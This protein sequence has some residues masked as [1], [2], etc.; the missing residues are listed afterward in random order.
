[1]LVSIAL[2]IALV[3]DATPGPT[4]QPAQ[5]SLLLAP[6]ISIAR[7]AQSPGMMTALWTKQ[8]SW[9]SNDKLTD[10][11]L[12]QG[13]RGNLYIRQKD[14][15]AAVDVRT[16][17]ERWSKTL[18]D[19]Y[20][21][22]AND[23]FLVASLEDG[24]LISLRPASGAVVWNLKLAERPLLAFVRG[25]LLVNLDGIDPK[26]GTAIWS[27]RTLEKYGEPVWLARPPHDAGAS[28]LIGG[29]A[30]GTIGHNI[31]IALD[32]TS[33]KTLWTADTDAF[34]GIAAGLVYMQDTW[35]RDGSAVYLDVNGQKN[36]ETRKEYVL[37]PDPAMNGDGDR[38]TDTVPIRVTTDSILIALN[39]WFYRYPRVNPMAARPLRVASDGTFLGGPID[40]WYYFGGPAGLT[41]VNF[42]GTTASKRRIPLPGGQSGPMLVDDSRVYVG[43]GSGRLIEIDTKARTVTRMTPAQCKLPHELAMLDGVLLAAC[44]DERKPPTPAP[45]FDQPSGERYCPTPDRRLKV[46]GFRVN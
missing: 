41:L 34:V 5:T 6:S 43:S 3:V 10:V 40:G 16:G 32:S 4:P 33:G 11:P 44:D 26:R 13:G 35:P 36:A 12:L 37:N 15:I 30:S 9:T 27:S 22:A 2:A 31:L 24:R 20:E 14:V 21:I 46:V 45:C 38:F 25:V 7:S 8:T 23:D 19:I 17:V 18:P 28:V 29:S 39:G 1:M 42:A